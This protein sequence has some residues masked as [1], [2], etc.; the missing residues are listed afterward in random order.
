MENKKPKLLIVDADL[1]IFLSAYQFKNSCNKIGS[2]GAKNKLSSLYNDLLEKINPDFIISFFGGINGRNYRYEYANLK[3]YKGHRNAEPYLDYFKPILKEHMEK[4][5]NMYPCMNI[6]ADD[7]V[8][9]S[10]YKYKDDYE[11]VF[12]FEDKDLKQIAYFANMTMTQYNPKDKKFTFITPE[13]GMKAWYTQCLCGDSTDNISGVEGIGKVGA[14]K[15]INSIQ[16]C[17]EENCFNTIRDAYIK[18][19]SLQLYEPIMLENWILLQM[20]NKNR[21]DFDI[22]SIPLIPYV[23]KKEEKHLKTL[24]D[25]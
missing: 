16:P 21:F 8:S 4:A 3:V 18:K 23:N 11:L 15:I 7:A 2:M 5:H 1:F 19:Y 24:N 9:I 20:L 25:L 14:E 13:E 22:N 6:E 12:C 10:A 17:T